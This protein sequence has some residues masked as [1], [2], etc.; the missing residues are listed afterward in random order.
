MKNCGFSGEWAK[1][2]RTYRL[3]HSLIP[4]IQDYANTFIPKNNIILPESPIEEYDIRTYAL[5]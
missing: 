1:L 2:N 5:S 3:P 4:F